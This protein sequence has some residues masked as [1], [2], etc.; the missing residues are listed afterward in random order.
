M[1]LT[2]I[3]SFFLAI[4]STPTAAAF[5]D[6]IPSSIDG[7]NTARAKL[8]NSISSA[9]GEGGVS[10]RVVTEK[11]LRGNNNV[12]RRVRGRNSDVTAQR[13]SANTSEEPIACTWQSWFE[14]NTKNHAEAC[15][16]LENVYSVPYICEDGFY[17]N[18]CCTVSSCTDPTL[19]TFGACHKVTNDGGGSSTGSEINDVRDLIMVIV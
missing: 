16:A 12:R 13:K 2:S 17:T 3:L 18:I 1:K 14:G 10:G 7:I 15:A 4:V 6:E 9:G 11:Q 8:R 19:N 5:T